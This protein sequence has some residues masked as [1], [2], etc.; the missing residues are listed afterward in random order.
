MSA[1]SARYLM[2]VHLVCAGLSPIARAQATNTLTMYLINDFNVVSGAAAGVSLDQVAYGD[3]GCTP[4]G[5]SPNP[6]GGVTVLQGT[7]LSHFDFCGQLQGT[8][9]FNNG[10]GNFTSTPGALCTGIPGVTQGTGTA[11][12]ISGVDDI[13]TDHSSSPQVLYLAGQGS[14]GNTYCIR[15]DLASGGFVSGFTGTINPG[16]SVAFKGPTLF[17]FAYYNGQN[18]AFEVDPTTMPGSIVNCYTF[19]LPTVSPPLNVTLN[20]AAYVPSNSQF[21]LGEAGGSRLLSWITATSTATVVADLCAWGGASNI[22]GLDYNPATQVL[23]ILGY[24]GTFSHVWLFHYEAAPSGFSMF[25]QGDCL[26]GTTT[27]VL[28]VA[29]VPGTATEGW[30]LASQTFSPSPIP[31]GGTFYCGIYQDTLTNYLLSIAPSTATAGN[32]VHWSYPVTTVWPAVPVSFVPSSLNPPVPFLSPPAQV[33]FFSAAVVGS[34][35]SCS[36]VARVMYQ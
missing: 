31:G 33:D 15:K 10:T 28:S 32:F 26:S 9:T 7:T 17:L 1:T 30:T 5:P 20:G 2:V 4:T 35:Y 18:S 24:R 6:T 29:N 11:P 21:L 25:A 23:A 34:T 12:H 27:I 13:A 8:N 36:N 22:L 14:T 19:T 3:N 16:Y